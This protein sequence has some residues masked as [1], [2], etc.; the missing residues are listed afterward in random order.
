MKVSRLK[1]FSNLF[2]QKIHFDNMDDSELFF[3]KAAKSAHEPE[4]AIAAAKV[5]E[6][7]HHAKVITSSMANDGKIAA[8]QWWRLDKILDD[9]CAHH[10][11]EYRPT[12]EQVLAMV[13]DDWW[14]RE[15]DGKAS[16]IIDPALYDRQAYDD[17]EWWP[18]HK[19]LDHFN[20]HHY[21]DYRRSAAQFV[22][23][24]N[25]YWSTHE[26]DGRIIDPALYDRARKNGRN[27]YSED[28][29]ALRVLEIAEDLENP[30]Q[31]GTSPVLIVG[32]R[33]SPA[34]LTKMFAPL[35]G[36]EYPYGVYI[37]PAPARGVQEETQ[38]SGITVA[39]GHV[40]EGSGQLE[41]LDGKMLLHDDLT[42]PR[43]LVPLLNHVIVFGKM[44][45]LS[46]GASWPGQD[47]YNR[48]LR[49]QSPVASHIAWV[50]SR[51]FKGTDKRMHFGRDDPHQHL[52]D[53]PHQHWR[54]YQY[55]LSKAESYGKWVAWTATD[56]DM[57]F[58]DV[59]QLVTSDFDMDLKLFC[60]LGRPPLEKL[61]SSRVRNIA[62]AYKQY[63]NDCTVTHDD[64]F[65]SLDRT[66]APD[67][68]WLQE[69][70]SSSADAQ[71]EVIDE[72]I[73][74][75]NASSG[76]IQLDGD[77]DVSKWLKAVEPI[78]KK[79]CREN[80]R[81]TA[82][83]SRTWHP[84]KEQI[85]SA[86]DDNWQGFES[87]K[88]GESPIRVMLHSEGK[89]YGLLS[90]ALKP[91]TL[92]D[93][94]DGAR[95]PPIDQECIPD[96]N[97]L[98]AYRDVLD[99]EVA[100][101]L[102]KE[103]HQFLKRFPWWEKVEGGYLFLSDLHAS[104]ML[105][106]R[107]Q[108]R[109]ARKFNRFAAQPKGFG[110]V[111][112][113]KTYSAHEIRDTTKPTYRIMLRS[114][115]DALV[116]CLK[117]NGI[118]IT[119]FS[120][121]EKRKKLR[122]LRLN[123]DGRVIYDIR[124][125]ESEEEMLLRE[126]QWTDLK[127][128]VDAYD[129]LHDSSYLFHPNYS[130]AV[131]SPQ[132]PASNSG[133]SPGTPSSDSPTEDEFLEFEFHWG[134]LPTL[135]QIKLDPHRYRGYSGIRLKVDHKVPKVTLLLFL[136][137][138]VHFQMDQLLVKDWPGR[139][140]Y[141]RLVD[142]QHPGARHIAWAYSQVFDSN[143]SSYRFISDKYENTWSG[144]EPVPLAEL[145]GNRIANIARAYDGYL[146]ARKTH[147]NFAWRSKSCAAPHA[148]TTPRNSSS[149]D[150]MDEMDGKAEKSDSTIH[151]KAGDEYRWMAVGDIRDVVGD[152]D[153]AER[154]NEVIRHFLASKSR[155]EFMF[156]S[157]DEID[158]I[159]AIY[160][161]S[162]QVDIA[163]ALELI[164]KVFHDNLTPFE[165]FDHQDDVITRY[166]KLAVLLHPDTSLRFEEYQWHRAD[167]IFK[168]LGVLKDQAISGASSAPRSKE[169]RA[170]NDEAKKQQKMQD[171]LN[172]M[173]TS[174]QDGVDDVFANLDYDL[175]DQLWEQMYTVNRQK[176]NLPNE[177]F[178]FEDYADH[179]WDPQ[180]MPSSQPAREAITLEPLEQDSLAVTPVV[181]KKDAVRQ[182]TGN[183][184][185]S[186]I[187]QTTHTSSES[188]VEDEEECISESVAESVPSREN[189]AVGVLPEDQRSS[190]HQP[191]TKQSADGP[192]GSPLHEFDES[193]SAEESTED[194]CSGEDCG[195]DV[196]ISDR[197]K[198]A[199]SLL[200]LVQ[201]IAGSSSGIPNEVRYGYPISSNEDADQIYRH[202]DELLRV[203]HEAERRDALLLSIK[204]HL[205][206]LARHLLE[207]DYFD[208][209]DAEIQKAAF[210]AWRTPLSVASA[211]DDNWDDIRDSCTFKT[212][213]SKWSEQ[214]DANDPNLSNHR[215][216]SILMYCIAAGD[217]KCVQHLITKD[218]NIR[219]KDLHGRSVLMIAAASADEKIFKMI[220][221]ALDDGVSTSFVQVVAP[222]DLNDTDSKG[223][224]A[225]NYA[226]ANDNISAATLLRA[227]TAAIANRDMFNLT[228][229]QWTGLS[230]NPQALRNVINPIV[231]AAGGGSVHP[232]RGV[233]PAQAQPGGIVSRA[234]RAVVPGQKSS[235]ASA[236]NPAGD[237]HNARPNVSVDDKSGLSHA[238]ETVENFPRAHWP[239][240]LTHV[241]DV[242]VQGFSW[243]KQHVFYFESGATDDMIQ[244]AAF[245][246][247]TV[248]DNSKNNQ[249]TPN[250]P[251]FTLWLNT[252][253]S[254]GKITYVP[255]HGV[256]VNQHVVDC[257]V[258]KLSKDQLKSVSRY[259]D[260]K[261]QRGTKS[262]LECNYE[263][264]FA[265]YGQ[266]VVATDC[267]WKMYVTTH[268]SSS[269]R[270]RTDLDYSSRKDF[271]NYLNG[272]VPDTSLV[273]TNDEGKDLGGILHGRELVG[274][275]GVGF[276]M[277]G[278]FQV[279]DGNDFVD[280]YKSKPDSLTYWIGHT[281]RD[282][283]CIIP[284]MH[285]AMVVLTLLYLFYR[286]IIGRR[287]AAA[288]AFTREQS[289][290]STL[291]RSRN[292]NSCGIGPDDMMRVTPL[293]RSYVGVILQVLWLLLIAT[294]FVILYFVQY[295][296]W[297][298]AD[299][300]TGSKL[301]GYLL[302]VCVA[303]E[304]G[305]FAI[306]CYHGWVRSVALIA[307]EDGA[308]STHVLVEIMAPVAGSEAAVN[309]ATWAAMAADPETKE[310]RAFVK[311]QK[312][313]E[314]LTGE[315]SLVNES[316]PLNPC[317]G[318]GT[319]TDVS[320]RSQTIHRPQ[321]I[322]RAEPPAF[323]S[324]PLP[325]LAE[326][327]DRDEPIDPDQLV[328][329]N[330]MILPVET[331]MVQDDDKMIEMH[332]FI[333]GGVP[334]VWNADF[335][336]FEPYDFEREA[337][338]FAHMRL[339]SGLPS[340]SVKYRRF[341]TGQ[342]SISTTKR[343]SNYI[344]ATVK[345]MSTPYVLIAVFSVLFVAP[346]FDVYY[347]VSLI[348]VICCIIA[349][350]F[351]RARRDS[352]AKAEDENINGVKVIRNR[353]TE[354]LPADELVITT[355]NSQK[356]QNDSF[357]Y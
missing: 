135:R 144:P 234:K 350:M 344:N 219:A 111:A 89:G 124:A 88:T 337:I 84:T 305:V 154:P 184:R 142:E 175:I 329:I 291:M 157:E 130:H 19:I 221:H 2:E 193:Q 319:L 314:R 264:K 127:P 128:G 87:L 163:E 343:T 92:A 16:V 236:R 171:T 216:E 21:N 145:D 336:F 8:Y 36:S 191:S 310:D 148:A 48:L 160:A 100:N 306:A 349:M 308:K 347:F 214:F 114:L 158:E 180:H 85:L 232:F 357:F 112:S 50:Y 332:R 129:G 295:K 20:T 182:A 321:L 322:T 323:Q 330:T 139:E 13:N 270:F 151:R 74:S 115:E 278:E 79:I 133:E 286:F 186:V 324:Q 110:R 258:K 309:Q 346:R 49:E 303:F 231:P 254:C 276:L 241:N 25:Y 29:D 169:R 338:R 213:T 355:K 52:R 178:D 95:D 215:G 341:F 212:F 260:A 220:L 41:M 352:S 146:L 120:D 206:G 164:R 35:T 63:L 253:S 26:H 168:Q 203:A 197:I 18:L 104:Q 70:K 156:C 272:Y 81:V 267:H 307:V 155:C 297:Y 207:T 15:H 96:E 72:V 153:F 179:G 56:V 4:E 274:R 299:D 204:E 167:A 247:A 205:D 200:A 51:N 296:G 140:Q 113:D 237:Q 316:T 225:F 273:Q 109:D 211:A 68:T 229:T 189:R 173:M 76:K 106:S 11:G 339:R 298:P 249:F 248:S 34:S 333:H 317:V 31:E 252:L 233:I 242:Q 80:F 199:A 268:N 23:I 227:A 17:V 302:L 243:K 38:D 28:M 71:K 356:Y 77:V 6:K 43:V 143:S 239:D 340:T 55:M 335:H 292:K 202:A 73:S 125:A 283:S 33:A 185:P 257:A 86:L 240:G 57:V 61:D 149:T 281:W 275:G 238:F 218:A 32:T 331:R 289:C 172:H 198:S 311:R 210:V 162:K 94:L 217:S 22:A 54:A 320:T 262:V 263:T 351:G 44:Y 98:S 250:K 137:L 188:S 131:Q 7:A 99:P 230:N 116:A 293:S 170:A 53:D 334:H 345:T 39:R 126:P 82:E 45:E 265:G 122:Y 279:L 10:F 117:Q 244:S 60:V 224:S 75:V 150:P 24:S 290:L 59:E 269:E 313:I 251:S 187:P 312:Q 108:V 326:A 3:C 93:I 103:Y 325:K 5:L 107:G 14:S 235:I 9:F 287:A 353:T 134:L 222:A 40:L 152:I 37:I 176:L 64:F 315:A 194:G 78:V 255:Y 65:A 12:E 266:E 300:R 183:N 348:L 62:N 132:T 136:H 228:P 208:K 282:G 159:A 271:Q 66:Q 101:V 69:E 285:L 27:D 342:C 102:R 118:N 147:K 123:S 327:S 166:K 177:G 141:R 90:E 121:V 223:W 97:P 192:P 196:M 259:L 119:R 354:W 190:A 226:V 165:E 46:T 284:I 105:K 318:V 195:E 47:E 67:G 174:P 280:Q 256:R 58:E 30:Y 42:I 1:S 261:V 304:A 288:F 277:D 181:E 138:S 328:I 301:Y 83:R 294:T 209:N 245:S 91:N 201:L 161:Q 246:V